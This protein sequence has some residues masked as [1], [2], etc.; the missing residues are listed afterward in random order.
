MSNFASGLYFGEVVHQRFAP[1]RHRLRYRMFQ[2]LFDLDEL[3]SL[4]RKLRFFS[5]NRGNVF[6]FYDSDHG[7]ATGG[8][9]RSYIEDLLSQAGLRA[10]GGR[11]ALLCMPRI[12][13][14]VF[15]PLSIFYC[16]GDHGKLISIVYEVNNTFGQRHSY[17]IPVDS[18]DY[19]GVCQACKKDFYVSPFMDMEMTYKFRLSLPGTTLTTSIDGSHASGA[20]LIFASFT[21]VRRRFSD[22]T[23]LSALVTYPFLTLGVVVAIHWEAVRLLAKGLR[24]RRRPTPPQ[25]VTIVEAAGSNPS[26]AR[27]AKALG[28]LHKLDKQSA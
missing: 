19:D 20:P 13:G 7:G 8:S 5:H 15:N 9:L 6:S 10:D 23:L 3:P 28:A 12:L 27:R 11:I 16:Y 2:G 25:S 24:L 18:P 17:L 26:D 4:G 22:G 21:G 14:F 1:R